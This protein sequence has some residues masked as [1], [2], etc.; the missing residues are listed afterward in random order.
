MSESTAPSS[1]DQ[2]VLVAFTISALE[3]AGIDCEKPITVRQGPLTE[4]V[5]PDE[6]TIAWEQAP[7]ADG[8]ADPPTPKWSVDVW[9]S[10]GVAKRFTHETA[11]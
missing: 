1:A 7:G 3:A 10:G 6:I 8:V 2:I 5:F 11:A 9:Q 4:V